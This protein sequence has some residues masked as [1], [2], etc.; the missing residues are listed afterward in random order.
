M[1]F[2]R[3]HLFQPLNRQEARSVLLSIEMRPPRLGLAPRLG[4]ELAFIGELGAAVAGTLNST[5][6]SIR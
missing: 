4:F 1:L 3:F 2:D 6:R 5:P